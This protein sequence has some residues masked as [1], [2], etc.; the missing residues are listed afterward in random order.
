M[1]YPLQ[2]DLKQSNSQLVMSAQMSKPVDIKTIWL[3][4]MTKPGRG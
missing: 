1:N 3:T 2:I 4:E